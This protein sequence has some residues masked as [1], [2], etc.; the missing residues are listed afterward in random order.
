MDD[1]DLLFSLTDYEWN[2]YS[3]YRLNQSQNQPDYIRLEL[4]RLISFENHFRTAIDQL[5]DKDIVDNKIIID[6]EIID[7]SDIIHFLDTF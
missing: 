5:I 2:L 6:N 4:F 3:I 7:L 1:L